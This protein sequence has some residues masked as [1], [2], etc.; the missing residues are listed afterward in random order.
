MSSRQFGFH[1]GTN[2]RSY[3]MMFQELVIF[4]T[5]IS[6]NVNFA[7]LDLSKVFNRMNFNTLVAQSKKTHLLMQV[8]NFAKVYAPELVRKFQ[9]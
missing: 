7:S 5:E 9:L 1:P 2:C 4:Y 3:V 8:A 6:S